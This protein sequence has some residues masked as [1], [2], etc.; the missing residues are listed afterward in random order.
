MITIDGKEYKEED[1]NDEQKYL[2][3]Q[4]QNIEVQLNN[5]R[6]QADQLTAAKK[7]FSDAMM[8]SLSEQTDEG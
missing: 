3:A 7:M 4:L 2:V 6:F 1:L 5:L 8:Q